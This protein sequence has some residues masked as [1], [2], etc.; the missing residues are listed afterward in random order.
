MHSFKL[1]KPQYLFKTHKSL[2][3]GSAGFEPQSE[4]YWTYRILLAIF[5]SLFRHAVVQQLY[6]NGGP[7]EVKKIHKITFAT[8]MYWFRLVTAGENKKIRYIWN[9]FDE[10]GYT[11]IKI[12]FMLKHKLQKR[13]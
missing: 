1:I 11:D 3:A 5:L 6:I 7:L 8:G 13:W 12:R 4:C 10:T 2:Y 9:L